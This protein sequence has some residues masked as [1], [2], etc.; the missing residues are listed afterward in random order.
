MRLVLSNKR[1][2]GPGAG[3]CAR[4]PDRSCERRGYPGFA[5]NSQVPFCVGPITIAPL[6]RASAPP[7]YSA[8]GKRSGASG[9]SVFG[10]R[11]IARLNGRRP[12]Q[13]IEG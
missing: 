4:L 11:P 12:L 3:P 2:Q 13:E 9:S 10:R 5:V 6:A 8:S 1:A 7:F